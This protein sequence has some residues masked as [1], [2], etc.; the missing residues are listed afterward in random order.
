KPKIGLTFANALRSILR[1]DPDIIMIGEIRDLETA[2]I[3]VQAA[4]TGHLVLATLHTN[5]AAATITRLLDMGVEDYLVTSTVVGIQAQRLVRRLCP[6]CREPYE[7][8]PELV[9]QIDP[10][11]EGPMT[12]YRPKGCKQCNGQG[13]RGRMGVLEVLPMTDEVRR[14]VLQHAES[15]EI[16]KAAVAAGMRSMY[17]DG[18]A[19]ARR[20]VTTLEEVV[21]VTSEQ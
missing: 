21:R 15:Q 20:G 9:R 2:Q 16:H 18:V 13:Y 1:Q 4:L 7:A 12:L 14:L 11:A 5:T 19:K 8:L 17:Q 6:D 3:A 10:Q